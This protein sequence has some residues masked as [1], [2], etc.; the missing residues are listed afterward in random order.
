[1][2]TQ[3]T[4]RRLSGGTVK[5]AGM[6]PDTAKAVCVGGFQ[7]NS[8]GSMTLRLTIQEREAFNEVRRISRE[9]LNAMPAA[10]DLNLEQRRAVDRLCDVRNGLTQ[11]MQ[12]ADN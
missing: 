4:K 1:M 3:K 6:V 12:L 2:T 7:N 11:L 10:K 5:A 8:A 9:K